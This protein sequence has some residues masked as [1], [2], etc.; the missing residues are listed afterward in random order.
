MCMDAVFICPLLRSAPTDFGEPRMAQYLR[1]EILCESGGF[2]RALWQYGYGSTPLGFTSYAPNAIERSHRMVK[3]L[4][5]PGKVLLD[6]GETMVQVCRAVQGRV[7]QGYYSGLTSQVEAPWPSLL[8]AKKRQ[9]PAVLQQVED[10][11]GTGTLD[12]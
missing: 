3:H 8:E 9:V 6:L 5:G 12:A 7:E 11:A 2:F 1:S 10:G 4:L